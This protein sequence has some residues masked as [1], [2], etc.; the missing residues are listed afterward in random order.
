MEIQELVREVRL[1]V[2]TQE[3]VVRISNVTIE[4]GVHVALAVM[5]H[6]IGSSNRVQVG[7]VTCCNDVPRNGQ[8]WLIQVLGYDIPSK[9]W[10]ARALMRESD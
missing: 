5:D 10:I 1:L 8:D 7:W 6:P 3:T 9:T 2:P 4:Q